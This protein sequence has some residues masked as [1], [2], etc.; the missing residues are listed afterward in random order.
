M[1]ASSTITFAS[2]VP[3]TRREVRGSVTFDSSYP[4]GGEAVTLAQLGLTRLDWLSVE[5]TDGYVPAWDG[6]T[7][8]PKIKLFWVDT[9]VDGAP[10]AE[11]TAATDASAV[12][13]RFHAVGA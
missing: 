10:L 5:T 9:T 4:T 11:V 8:A 2:E 6:S 12:V 3:G 13:V 1:A 7:S